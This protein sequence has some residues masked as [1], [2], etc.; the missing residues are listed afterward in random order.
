MSGP[1]KEYADHNVRLYQLFGLSE[2][3]G[4]YHV[5]CAAERIIPGKSNAERTKYQT[6]I[7]PTIK[8]GRVGKIKSLLRVV[9]DQFII[10]DGLEEDDDTLESFN[11]PHCALPKSVPF[12]GRQQE[13]QDSLFFSID[14][15]RLFRVSFLEKELEE[16]EDSASPRRP[17]NMAEYSKIVQSS[18][19]QRKN[20]GLQGLMTL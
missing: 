20:H 11:V 17:Q 4:L 18:I 19:E 9:E 16:P 15:R 2:T 8:D 3:L 5:L 6:V 12:T 10:P 13:V 7:A 1:A 14:A